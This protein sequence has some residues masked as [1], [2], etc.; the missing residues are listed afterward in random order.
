ME[1]VLSTSEERFWDETDD[2]T[3]QNA[4]DYAEANG[5]YK[6]KIPR[7]NERTKK[8]V[9]IINESILLP[10]HIMLV[11]ENCHL[12][13]QDGVYTN[14]IR[15]KNC[16]TELGRKTEGKQTDIHIVGEG[17]PILDGGNS[18]GLLECNFK[19]EY[20]TN[21]KLQQ[22]IDSKVWMYINTLVILTNVENF[23]LCNVEISN[24]RW[25][26][27][28]FSNC[29]YGKIY[30]V[31]INA[32]DKVPNQDGIHLRHGCHDI[33]VERITGVSGDDFIVFTALFV[34][35]QLFVEDESTDISNINVKD[36]VGSSCRQGVV[37]LR[38]QDEFKLHDIQIENV[39]QAS[40]GDKNI[41]PYTGVAVGCL[42]YYKKR[43]APMG[44]IKNI[45]IKNIYS[46]APSA[47]LLCNN[48]QNLQARNVHAIDSQW[49]VL[50]NQVSMDNVSISDIYYSRS[51]TVRDFGLNYTLI[52]ED[53]VL[54]CGAQKDTDTYKNVIVKNYYNEVE[55]NVVPIPKN[56]TDFIVEEK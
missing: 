8:P 49:A 15:N 45:E 6:V 33:S 25:W 38:A 50:G 54:L 3:I 13:L 14:I 22:A 31:N 42:G 27:T 28:L 37:V 9:W 29:S 7:L 40:Y 26:S 47:L 10:S 5:I 1:N 55:P 41:K 17:Y 24:Q 39:I 21:T 36:I 23:T 20:K 48:V 34:G 11:L 52:P 53:K 43:L 51:R 35:A 4:L 19:A 46:F 30:D 56:A 44:S 2:K 16:F 32:N 12:K 18:N